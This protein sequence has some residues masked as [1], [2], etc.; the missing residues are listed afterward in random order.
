LALAGVE[1][2][3]GVMASSLRGLLRCVYNMPS[4]GAADGSAMVALVAEID[5]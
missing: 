2:V 5:R 4:T 3:A 1:N